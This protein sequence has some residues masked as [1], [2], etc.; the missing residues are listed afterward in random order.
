MF[1]EKTIGDIEISPEANVILREAV[2]G[3]ALD[4]DMIFMIHTSNHDY[5]FPG[6]GIEKGENHADALKREFIEE[7]GYLISDEIECVGII[8]EKRKDIYEDNTYFVMKSY[9]YQLKIIKKIKEQQ[10]E[11]YEKELDFKAEFVSVFEAYNNNLAL[12]NNQTSAAVSPWVL[13]ETIAL[14]HI[15]DGLDNK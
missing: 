4:G 7:T 14:R 8:T 1:F 12:T 5:K 11:P 3:I 6:G 15:V 13:R 2:R 9:Y 10:L